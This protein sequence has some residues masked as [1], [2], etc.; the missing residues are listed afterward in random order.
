[1]IQTLLQ[2]AAVA[3]AL[4]AGPA[5]PD[6]PI[7]APGTRYS[8]LARDVEVTTPSVPSADIQ[9]D[10]NILDLSWEQAAVL[11][12]FTQ[13]NPVEGSPASQKTE[14]LVLV[15][16]Q[17]L[18]FAVRAYDDNPAGIRAT[19]SERDSFGFSDDYVRFILDT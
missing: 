9:I 13:F 5:G 2:V 14:V 4:S 1:M 3:S 6:G 15:D 18:Y 12:G 16:K 8:G 7:D 10:G 11:D 19:L 17:A